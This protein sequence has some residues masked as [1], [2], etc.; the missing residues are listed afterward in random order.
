MYLL[1]VEGT[2][3]CVRASN[4][5]ELWRVD[6]QKDFGVVQNFFGVGSNPV[7]Y[8]DLLLVMVGGSPPESQNVAPGRLDRVLSNS[9]GVVAFDKFSG[10]V[11]YQAIDELASYSSLKLAEHA[12]RPWCFAFL[13][14]GL[15]AFDPRSGKLDFRFPW[16]AGIL[17]SVNASVPVVFDGHVFISETYGPGSVLLQFQPDQKPQVLWQDEL[18]SRNKAM[19]T[20]WN[21]AIY[22]RDTCTDQAADTNTTPNFGAS[23]RKQA[24]SSGPREDLPDVPCCTLMSISSVLAKM[25]CCG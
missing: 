17:E 9:C 15:A 11:V 19:Q 3:L 16:R 1:G 14:G 12:G 13:R 25:V 22:T 7:I 2:L 6:T 4:G 10:E 20:H 24:N 18:R 8:Q 21:T 23:P 5:K